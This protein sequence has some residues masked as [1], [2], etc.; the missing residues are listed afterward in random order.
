MHPLPK[1]EQNSRMR[2]VTAIGTFV[3][4]FAFVPFVRSPTVCYPPNYLLELHRRRWHFE[5]DVRPAR[6][7]P[8]QL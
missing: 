5:V 6:P 8:L 2:S 1:L 7:M 3:G 4:H